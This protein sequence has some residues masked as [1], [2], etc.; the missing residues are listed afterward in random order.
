MKKIIR[1]TESDLARIV[2]RVI[3]ENENKNDILQC[4]ATAADLNYNDL[5][6]IAPCANLLTGTPTK[7]DIEACF[8]GANGVIENK[9]KGMSFFEKAQ[10]VANLSLKSAGCL[11]V[12]TGGMTLPGYGGTNIDIKE[13]RRRRY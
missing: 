11:G 13:S 1:L 5:I 6:N 7:E 8:E 10:Y 4:V 3:R 9:T 2:R 12:S